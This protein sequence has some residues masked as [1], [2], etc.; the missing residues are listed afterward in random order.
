MDKEALFQ[1]IIDDEPD[2][3]EQVNDA[4]E[5]GCLNQDDKLRIEILAAGSTE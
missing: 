2:W 4:W 1:A 5:S 3:R